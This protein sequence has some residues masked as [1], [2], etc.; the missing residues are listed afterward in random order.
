MHVR[1]QHQHTVQKHLEP[2]MDKIEQHLRTVFH[3]SP[4][5]RDFEKLLDDH[6]F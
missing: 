4:Y 6:C 3:F 2:R 5:Q 1:C